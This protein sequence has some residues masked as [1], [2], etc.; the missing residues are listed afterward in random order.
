MSWNTWHYSAISRFRLQLHL[1]CRTFILPQKCKC[2]L[3]RLLGLLLTLSPPCVKV[4]YSFVINTLPSCTDAH[5]STSCP[6]YPH[7][8]S[9]EEGAT[10]PCQEIVMASQF[11]QWAL[12]L[13]WTKS[14]LCSWSMLQSQN[15]GVSFHNPEATF[16]F[17]GDLFKSAAIQSLHQWINKHPVLLWPSFSCSKVIT[18]PPYFSAA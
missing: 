12:S 1:F 5:L 4:F 9:L 15:L 18:P 11:H 17:R 16:T 10:A 2:L 14:C 6:Q 8:I 7:F 3:G 13:C